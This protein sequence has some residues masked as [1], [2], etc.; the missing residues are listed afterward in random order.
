M[1]AVVL[2]AC[3]GGAQ[4]SNS[5]VQSTDRELGALAGA[6]IEDLAERSGMALQH[7]VRL[8]KRTR[9]QLVRYLRFKLDEELPEEEAEATVSSYALLGLV[10]DTLDLR[11]VLLDLYTEQVA[12]FYDPDSTALFILDDQPQVMLQ[13]LLVHE[14]V[15]A[16]QDQT[17]DLAALTDP[18]LGNDRQVA[19]QA[20]IE[21]HATL[22]MLEYMAE[23]GGTPVDL[24]AIAD[25]AARLRPALEGMAQFPAL[26]GAPRVIR[27]SLL[28]PYLEGAGYVQ[29]LWQEERH[30][31]PFGD[32]LPL[33][34]EQVM[35][36]DLG[37]VPVKVSLDVDGGRTVHTDDLGRFETGVVL[38][39]HLGEGSADLA[40]GW[41]GDRYALVETSEGLGLVWA[42]VWDTPTDRDRFARALEEAAPSMARGTRV[43]SLDVEGL[44]AVIVRIGLPSEVAV[45]VSVSS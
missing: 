31:P 9:E 19:A 39:T 23:Q 32:H 45:Q 22:V 37:D 41:G 24:G 20:A 18:A 10:P 13:G 29:G 5:L 21:G 44:A 4:E 12:G 6:L 38:D 42:S 35:T 33:S 40:I 27:E 16:V 3:S 15:H 30:T 34:T 26:A 1:A 28:F 36:G 25:F 8:E 43:E 2:M 11:G 14:L 7:P 17:A